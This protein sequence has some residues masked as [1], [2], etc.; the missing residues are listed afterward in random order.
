M[1]A[2]KHKGLRRQTRAVNVAKVAGTAFKLNHEHGNISF[3]SRFDLVSSSKPLEIHLEHSEIHLEQSKILEYQYGD[4]CKSTNA[5]FW[6]GDVF[7]HQVWKL[8]D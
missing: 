5:F 3:A 4:L 2:H 7:E 8:N 6:D 1:E